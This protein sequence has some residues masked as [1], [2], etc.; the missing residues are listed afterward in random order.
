MPID[1]SFKFKIKYDSPYRL[2]YSQKLCDKYPDR[3]PVVIEKSSSDKITKDIE[4]DRFLVPRSLL[5]SEFIFIIRKHIKMDQSQAIFL[6]I[7]NVLVPINK[8]LGE[9]YHELKDPDGF[10]Y[11]KYSCENTFG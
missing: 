1:N 7:N 2:L 11:M 5:M 4:K 6:F 3:V 10:L 9:I 8:A